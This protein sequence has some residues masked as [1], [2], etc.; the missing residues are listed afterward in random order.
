[1]EFLIHIILAGVWAVLVH[2]YFEKKYA[3]KMKEIEEYTKKHGGN[4]I[5]K[6][7]NITTYDEKGNVR[8]RI[9][10]LN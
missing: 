3:K 4:V 1:M 10:K 2:I 5:D 6:D 8:V 7:G 9:G